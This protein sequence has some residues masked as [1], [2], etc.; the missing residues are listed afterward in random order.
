MKMR[1]L[2]NRWTCPV[3]SNILKPHDLVDDGAC[4][5]VSLAATEIIRVAGMSGYHT[6]VIVDN[7]EYFFDAIGILQAAPLFSHNLN[8]AKN[9]GGSKT[10]V[11]FIG[12]SH[13]DGRAMVEA[14][15]EFFERGSYDVFYKNCNT[16]SD[17]ALYMLTKTRIPGTYNR[18]ERFVTAT[19]P[20]S[21]S[22]LNRIF[23]ALVESSG[24]TVQGDI[25]TPNPV[26]ADFSVDGVIASLEGDDE[27]EESDHSESDEVDKYVQKVLSETP[28]H[29]EEVIIEKDGSYRIVEDEEDAAGKDASKNETDNAEQVGANDAPMA[30]A[31][32]Q[33]GIKRQGTDDGIEVPLSKRQRRRQK[34]LEARGELPHATAPSL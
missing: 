13:F 4:H 14:L 31:D 6:S 16:F 25:Y 30:D 12:Y 24:V 19:K 1:A 11:T 3:C 22:L 34:I 7:L 29:V 15:H 33:D 18:I 21:I 27:S 28:A 10:V 9:P 32:Q 26:S 20:V 17:A 5:E 23:K 8:E 2:N